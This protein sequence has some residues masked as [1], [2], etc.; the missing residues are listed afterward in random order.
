MNAPDRRHQPGRKLS[1]T[2]KA[3]FVGLFLAILGAV[4]LVTAEL[5]FRLRGAKA[6]TVNPVKVQVDP[7]GKFFQSDS[8]LGYRHLP[9]TF[10]I[11][12]EGSYQFQATH[13][14]DSLRITHAP[15]P[16]DAR[17]T[18]DCEQIWLFG[19]SFTHGWSVNDDETFAWQLQTAF[20]EF[21]VINYGVNGYGTIH[22]LIQLREA[23]KTKSPRLVVLIYAGFHDSRN[24]FTRARRKTLAPY[25]QLGPLVQ[26]YA[27]LDQTGALEFHFADVEYRPFPFMRYSSFIHELE[28]KY[29]DWESAHARPQ[30]VS[31]ALVKEIHRLTSAHSLT[32]GIA[33]IAEGDH[34]RAFAHQEGIPTRDIA[35]DLNRPENTNQPFDPHPSALAHRQYATDLADFIKELLSL[36]PSP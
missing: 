33:T 16:S 11:T 23:L 3:A 4:V 32:L 36:D 34:M 18:G 22:S 13:G 9:G 28:K 35:L 15:L 12:I 21:E 30:D 24:A 20:P 27:R 5:A 26:P 31:R 7:G 14:A 17:A 29:N 2:K 25:N 6:W 10:S 19:C 1:S 8:L